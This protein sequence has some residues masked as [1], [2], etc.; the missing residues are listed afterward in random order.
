[1][2]DDSSCSVSAVNYS[3]KVIAPHLLAILKARDV[4][5]TVAARAQE[6][7]RAKLRDEM[8][9]HLTRDCLMFEKA[10]AV[11]RSAHLA[12]TAR[13]AAV[14]AQPVAVRCAT[15]VTQADQ[16]CAK[17]AFQAA[18]LSD[19]AFQAFHPAN[20]KRRIEYTWFDAGVS[21]HGIHLC[22]SNVA[23]EGCNT[24]MGTFASKVIMLMST[25]AAG[26]ASAT[27]RSRE[28][29]QITNAVAWIPS[30]PCRLHPLLTRVHAFRSTLVG[31]KLLMTCGQDIALRACV[32]NS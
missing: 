28:R 26:V 7:E 18:G 10:Q 27:G 9:P 21:C 24:D 30:Q 2:Q 22:T 19:A 29:L 4:S 12:R 3:S 5:P 8:L 11:L 6:H 1:M 23:H 17:A 15:A 32:F 16:E 13:C 31:H 20:L 14:D 25:G